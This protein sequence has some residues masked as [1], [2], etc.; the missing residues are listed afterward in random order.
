MEE[1]R[2]V[3]HKRLGIILAK[4]K[5]DRPFLNFKLP[6]RF[7]EKRCCADLW[8]EGRLCPFILCVLVF[9][10]VRE[11]IILSITAPK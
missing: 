7:G 11:P 4:A 3:K 5:K 10:F 1:I 9:L 6:L 2:Q 8:K